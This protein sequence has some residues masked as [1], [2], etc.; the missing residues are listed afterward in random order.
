MK[1]EAKDL[2]IL[3]SWGKLFCQKWLLLSSGHI[4]AK[5]KQF[6]IRQRL[7]FLKWQ[8]RDRKQKGWIS[9]F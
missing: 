5:E 9:L 8:Q 2:A 7:K 3:P 6:K 1:Q 4:I